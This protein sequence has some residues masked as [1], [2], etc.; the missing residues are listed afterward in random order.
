MGRYGTTGSELEGSRSVHLSY[1]DPKLSPSRVL[2]NPVWGQNRRVFAFGIWAVFALL[3]LVH[4]PARS[5]NPSINQ[6]N[7]H[8]SS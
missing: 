3:A 6:A 8:E 4:H 7:K 5:P 2:K 1:R